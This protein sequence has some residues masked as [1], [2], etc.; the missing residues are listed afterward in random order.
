MAMEET[1]KKI[2]SIDG[3][4]VKLLNE[5]IGLAKKIGEEKRE[6]KENV[7]DPARE[8]EVI[9]KLVEKNKGD[10]PK[11]S[12]ENIFREIFSVSRKAQQ[13]LRVTYLG[14]EATF[15]HMAALKQFGSQC[16][17]IP[18]NSIAEIFSGVEKNDCDFGVVPIENSLEGSVTS[19]YDMLMNRKLGIVAEVSLEINH[20]LISKNRLKD[21][22]KLYTHPMALAQCRQWIAKNLPGVEILEV[23]STSKSVESASLYLNSAGIG[24]ELAAQKYGLEIIAR[25]IQDAANNTT[26]FLVIGKTK[27]KRAPKNKTSIVFSTKH[28][29]GALFNALETLKKNRLNMTKIQSRPT[30]EKKWEYVFF[31]DIQGFIED[32]NVKAALKEMQKN[33]L[34]LEVLGSYPEKTG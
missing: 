5:R 10:F 32:E 16:E 14:P 9:K 27:P 21:I 7:Y 26:R 15:T 3:E 2:D 6:K 31:V 19:T 24:S 34:F 23:S 4:I 13:P 18:F 30:K 1:R 33:T 29:A 28:E 11:E 20:N 22:K 25:N 12:V 17:F 8:E